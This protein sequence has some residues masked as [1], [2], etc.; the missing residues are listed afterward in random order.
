M[1]LATALDSCPVVFTEG[2]VIER[3]RR[4]FAVTLDPVVLH[5]GFIYEPE[6]KELLRRIYAQYIELAGRRRAPVLI[7]TPTRRTNQD[8][9]VQAGLGDRDVNGDSVR[10]LQGIRAT[11]PEFSSSVLV[12]GLMGCRGDAYRAQEALSSR[13]GHVFHR[14]QAVFLAEAGADFLFG[15]TL[16]AVSEALGLAMAMAD[17]GA[18]YVLSFVIRPDGALLDGTMLHDAIAR[19]DRAVSPHPL[20]YMVNCVHPSILLR[21]LDAPENRTAL[22]RERLVGIQGNASAKSPEELDGAPELASDGRDAWIDGMKR[23]RR[24]HP[25]RVF[26]GCCGTDDR[27][28]D[29]LV[30]ALSSEVR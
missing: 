16:P 18:P 9:L 19:I 12:G 20:A 15:A 27:Y 4:E 3:L 5:A 24:D 6:K 30:Q 26:G 7:M 28:I 22:V 13:E 8:R 17:T 2:A 1:D 10:F 11:Y 29:G 25:L 21:A 23:L 14:S